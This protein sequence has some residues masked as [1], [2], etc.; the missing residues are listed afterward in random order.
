M[1]HPTDRIEHTTAFVTQVVEH[2]LEREISQWVHHEGSIERPITPWA[3]SLPRIYRSQTC[4]HWNKL[5]MCWNLFKGIGLSIYINWYTFNYMHYKMY[6]ILIRY[7]KCFQVYEIVKL[8]RA[9]QFPFSFSL[10]CDCKYM[11]LQYSF[12]KASC[13]YSVYHNVL[14][15]IC[16]CIL[17]HVAIAKLCI[18]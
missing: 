17:C 18:W 5:I 11:S 16:T 7:W 9:I 1:H 13:K 8:S 15:Y 3:D 6:N 14:L 10:P 12:E 2:W 4:L